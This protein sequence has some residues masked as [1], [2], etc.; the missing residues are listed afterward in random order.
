MSN[1]KASIDLFITSQ[2]IWKEREAELLKQIEQLRLD[3]RALTNSVY[4]LKRAKGYNYDAV[5]LL[6]DLKRLINRYKTS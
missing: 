2:K 6:D 3:N 4:E 1:T 5:A